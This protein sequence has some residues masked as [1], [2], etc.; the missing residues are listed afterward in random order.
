LDELGELGFSYNPLKL[1]LIKN[2]GT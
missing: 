2:L 1:L